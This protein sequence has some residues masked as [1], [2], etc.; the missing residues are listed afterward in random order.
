MRLVGRNALEGVLESLAERPVVLLRG[1]R[2]A[3]KT[4]IARSIAESSHPSTLLSLDDAFSRGA[5]SPSPQ[6]WIDALTGPVVIDEVQREPA[7]L[8][9]I[10]LSVDRDRTAGRFLLTGSADVL[11]GPKVAE[12]LAGRMD[13]HTLWPL[14][15]GE[16]RGVRE[17]FVDAVFASGPLALEDLPVDRDGLVEAVLAGGFPEPVLTLSERG[18]ARWFDSYLTSVIERDVRDLSG[19]TG[20]AVMPRVLTALAARTGSQLNLSEVSRTVGVPRTTLE[21]YAALFAATFLVRALPAWSGSIAKQLARSPKVLFTDSGL[22]AHLLRAERRVLRERPELFGVL[23]EDYVA[24]EVLKQ[25]SWAET[26]CSAFHFRTQGGAEVDLVLEGPG[27]ALVGVE[28]KAARSL[29]PHDVKGMRVFAESV[30]DRFHRGVILHTGSRAVHL[31]GEVYALP[32]GSLWTLGARP[33][34]ADAALV[35]V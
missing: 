4:V 12:S 13:V 31:G 8:S 24:T 28:T 3:G 1:A 33:Q 19:V 10:K 11:T 34:P 7:V 2:Q 22:L 21:R 5:L 23:L 15:A 14:S 9:A 18:R 26:R 35:R 25:M 27:G 6:S 32:V 16:L 29:G 20:L 30:G 17:G